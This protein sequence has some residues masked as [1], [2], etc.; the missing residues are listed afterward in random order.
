MFPS[1]DQSSGVS[2]DVHLSAYSSFQVSSSK[3]I[4]GHISQDY[5]L[6]SAIGSGWGRG[7]SRLV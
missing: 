6:E 1:L 5:R 7:D 2:R 3:I 4:H